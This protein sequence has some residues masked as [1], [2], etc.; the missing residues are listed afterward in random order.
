MLFATKVEIG[1]RIQLKRF[2]AQPIIGFVHDLESEPMRKRRGHH[3][4][5]VIRR[6]VHIDAANTETRIRLRSQ[7]RQEIQGVHL[8]DGVCPHSST[9]SLALQARNGSR[10]GRQTGQLVRPVDAGTGLLDVVIAEK[11]STQEPA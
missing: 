3:V 6:G 7:L 1:V 9:R 2:A 4:F 8:L 11:I 5:R 10:Q